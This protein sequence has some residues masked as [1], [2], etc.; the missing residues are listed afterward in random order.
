MDGNVSAGDH[1]VPDCRGGKTCGNVLRVSV[2]VSAS[3]EPTLRCHRFEIPC[4][5]DVFPLCSA[6]RNLEEFRPDAL[7]SSLPR[8]FRPSPY[9]RRRLTS[10]CVFSYFYLAWCT[11]QDFIQCIR[12]VFIV[13]CFSVCLQR[14]TIISC[15]LDNFDMSG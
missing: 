3:T 15:A 13:L 9:L 8:R 10:K 6:D 14:F 11:R 7:P 1:F 4:S 12:F 5:E 2:P